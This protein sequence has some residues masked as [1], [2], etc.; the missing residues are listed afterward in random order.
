MVETSFLLTG[1]STL[2]KNWRGGCE[3]RF[4]GREFGGGCIEM[5]SAEG[6]NIIS[7]TS[8]KRWWWGAGGG[9][10]PRPCVGGPDDYGKIACA[11]RA[12]VDMNCFSSTNDSSNA[13]PVNK[14]RVP[15]QRFQRPLSEVP[16]N[17]IFTARSLF[18][19][20]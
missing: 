7:T 3:T 4:D 2:I 9:K 14:F 6:L 17:K 5:S 12:K 19:L 20:V 15:S 11:W 16:H 10:A 18:S 1:P 13:Y 8:R